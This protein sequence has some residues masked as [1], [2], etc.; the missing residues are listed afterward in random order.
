MEGELTPPLVYCKSL[1]PFIGQQVFALEGASSDELPPRMCPRVAGI[2]LKIAA[3]RIT[4]VAPDS[5]VRDPVDHIVDTSKYMET[6][7]LAAAQYD[8]D[9][10]DCVR[11]LVAAGT[12]KATTESVSTVS[13]S[14]VLSK[15]GNAAASQ[16]S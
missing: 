4:K 11:L 12:D 1:C 2:V 15:L 8:D 5:K 10:N 16:I 3:E 14:D 9:A 6:V 7:S 13:D